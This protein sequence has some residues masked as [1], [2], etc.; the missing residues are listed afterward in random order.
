ML[1]LTPSEFPG[2]DP[3]A[4]IDALFALEDACRTDDGIILTADRYLMIARKPA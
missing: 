2:F 1:L 4:D 3:V